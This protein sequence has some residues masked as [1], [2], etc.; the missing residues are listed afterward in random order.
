MLQ[1]LLREGPA[2]RNL[3]APGKSSQGMILHLASCLL[4]KQLPPFG[5]ACDV[6]AG[7][8]DVTSPATVQRAQLQA[9]RFV[10]RRPLAY[11]NP[12]CQAAGSRV[13]LEV[14]PTLLEACP[15]RCRCLDKIASCDVH[16]AIAG[17]SSSAREALLPSA[18]ALLAAVGDMMG[19]CQPPPVLEQATLVSCFLACIFRQWFQCPCT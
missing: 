4:V 3:I 7:Q 13:K 1:R 6:V 2:R 18:Q 17:V 19:A 16:L 8:D 9:L 12:A 10:N 5:L 11:S 15:I 14:F